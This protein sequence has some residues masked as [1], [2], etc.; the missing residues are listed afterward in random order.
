MYNTDL[1]YTNLRGANLENAFLEEANFQYANLETA[2]LK[3]A[4]LSRA[5]LKGANLRKAHLTGANLHSADL[6]NADLTG[7]EKEIDSAEIDFYENN[8]DK[9]IFAIAVNETECWLLTLFD[10]KKGKL[11][12]ENS[13][14]HHLNQHLENSK[15]EIKSKKGE[16]EKPIDPKKKDTKQYERLSDRFADDKDLLQIG[17]AH[18]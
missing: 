10:I 1:S 13:C 9:I 2:Y 12:I 4:K 11:P 14:L 7:A 16:Y 8:K 15:I 18:V 3:E 6:S 5:N 17:R